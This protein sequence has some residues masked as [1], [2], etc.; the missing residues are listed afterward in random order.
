MLYKHHYISIALIIILGFIIDLVFEN[1]Q[2][3]I[4]NNLL[5]LCLRFLREIIKSLHDVIDK[6]LMEKSTVLF[7]K[8]HYLLDYLT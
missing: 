1:L 7:M 5:P 6:Y 3:D 2:N 8:F 4:S